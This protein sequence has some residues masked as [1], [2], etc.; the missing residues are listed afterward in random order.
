[1]L[2]T[3]YESVLVTNHRHYVK[4]KAA[5]SS[6]I[7]LISSSQQFTLL[8]NVQ[9]KYNEPLQLYGYT[10]CFINRTT[11]RNEITLSCLSFVVRFMKHPVFNLLWGLVSI[12]LSQRNYEQDCP[13]DPFSWWS[14]DETIHNVL[15]LF[16]IIEKVSLTSAQV[17]LECNTAYMFLKTECVKSVVYSFFNVKFDKTQ[18]MNFKEINMNEKIF[19]SKSL[20]DFYEEKTMVNTIFELN[21]SQRTSAF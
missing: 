18:A 20:F 14:F 6:I 8:H 2:A 11:R 10:G 1:M 21:Y 3:S 7:F 15:F 19:L 13:T 16:L 12:S 9:N 4:R 5:V 17:I